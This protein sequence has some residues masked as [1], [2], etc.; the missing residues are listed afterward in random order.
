V[1]L[2]AMPL[3][4]LVGLLHRDCARSS[5]LGPGSTSDPERHTN[6][7]APLVLERCGAFVVRRMI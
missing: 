4:G 1:L 2:R 6:A 3:L 7:P 5:P